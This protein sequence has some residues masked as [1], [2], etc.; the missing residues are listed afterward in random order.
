MQFP[1]TSIHFFFF[2]TC[3]FRSDSFKYQPFNIRCTYTKWHPP[4]P[5]GSNLNEVKGEES[6]D[7]CSM[8][9]RDHCTTLD[10]YI[11]VCG[12]PF[13]WIAISH[14]SLVKISYNTVFKA[15]L[16]VSI[17]LDPSPDYLINRDYSFST[18]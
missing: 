10:L 7:F 3:G 2:S 4:K 9:R 6:I 14:L 17:F 5:R 16:D 11:Y 1:S 13:A 18:F 15:D 8:F 12:V